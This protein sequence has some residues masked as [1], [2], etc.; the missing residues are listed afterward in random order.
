MSQGGAFQQRQHPVAAVFARDVGQILN[1]QRLEFFRRLVAD[2]V[3]GNR[4]GGQLPPLLQQIVLAQGADVICVVRARFGLAVAQDFPFLLEAAGQGLQEHRLAH[5]GGFQRG[6]PIV[7]GGGKLAAAV[8]LQQG[9]QSVLRGLGIGALAVVVQA[10]VKVYALLLLPLFEGGGVETGGCR[11]ADYINRQLRLPYNGAAL[12]IAAVGD[13]FEIE[14][15]T[16]YRFLQQH[17]FITVAKGEVG[18]FIVV[19]KPFGCQLALAWV[20]RKGGSG[21]WNGSGSRCGGQFFRHLLLFRLVCSLGGGRGGAAGFRRQHALGCLNQREL[22]GR[23]QPFAD[24]SVHRCGVDLIK[25]AAFLCAPLGGRGGLTGQQG[26][27]GQLHDFLHIVGQRFA[28]QVLVQ[29]FAVGCGFFFAG[30]LLPDLFDQL[31][32]LRQRFLVFAGFRV[33]IKAQRTGLL[34]DIALLEADRRAGL[35]QA[36]VDNMGGEIV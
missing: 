8:E 36:A 22:V 20:Y 16:G 13:G 10:V 15:R 30:G 23:V 4:R 7:G 26:V 12:L 5:G 32:E 2:E 27:I 3:I 18:D 34:A 14:L 21:G 31:L 1:Q 24:A 25:L 35:L 6:L 29:H 19:V 11:T 33:G 9:F 17:R 28:L